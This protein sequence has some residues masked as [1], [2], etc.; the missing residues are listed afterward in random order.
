MR[1]EPGDLTRATLVRQLAAHWGMTAR[2][3]EYV[4]LGAGS[5]HWRVEDAAGESWFVTADRLTAM[6]ILDG[7]DADVNFTWLQS[8]YDTATALR[9]SGLDFVVAP[10]ACLNGQ[11]VLRVS[12]D[13]AVAVLPYV[14]GESAGVSGQWRDSANRLTA[15]GL[16]GRLHSVTPPGSLKRWQ[17]AVPHRATVA[18]LLGRLNESWESGPYGE[19]TR[20]LLRSSRPRLDELLARYDGMAAEVMASPEPWVVTHGE[21]HSGNFIVGPDSALHLVDWDTVRLAPRERDLAILARRD[22]DVMAAHQAEA[23]PIVPNEAAIDLF[24]L[25]WTLADICAYVARFRRDHT[26][27]E[28]DARFFAGLSRNLST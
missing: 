25:R 14:A 15:A 23:G 21:P 12:G 17:P 18:A 26:G 22:E 13:W 7:E 2:E 28:D 24:L 11:P 6:A 27:S 5:Y 1:D 19:Q 8:A 16:I 4:P 10:R 9:A 20:Q 3:I